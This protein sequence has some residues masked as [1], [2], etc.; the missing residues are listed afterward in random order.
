MKKLI[1]KPFLIIGLFVLFSCGDDFLETL[2]TED[3]SSASITA[4]TGNLLLGINGIHRSLYVR[5]SSQGE[6]GVGGVMITMDVMGEDFVMT[7]AGNGWYN[8]EYQ[9]NTHTNANAARTLYPY[10]IYYRF[11]RNA[12][13][14]INGADDAEGPQTIKNMVKGQALVYRAF[15]HF[16]LVQLY[17]SRYVAGSQNNQPGIPIRLIDDNETLARSSVEEVYAQIHADLDEAIQLLAGYERPNKSHLDQSVAQGIKARVALVQGN[18]QMAIQQAQIARQGYQLMTND[19]YVSGF[20]DYNNREWMWGSH[21]Q[22]DQTL[23]FANFGAYVSRNFNSTNIRT[24]PKAIFSVLYDQLPENDIRR[25][26]WD[27]SGQHGN[28]PAGVTLPSNFVKRP[29][30]SQ[31]FIAAG[32]AD[33]R[34]DVVYMRAAE[35]YLIEAEAKARL[36]DADAARV[37]FELVSPRD[38]EYTM[39]TNTGQA[40]ID[41]ILFY[42]RIEL[43]GEGFRWLD[44][45]RLNQSLDRNG[46]NH[47]ANLINNLFDVPAGDNRWTYQIPQDEI[48]NNPLVEQ[49]PQ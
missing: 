34:M 47:Q 32:T 49:N 30:T 12:N 17:G 41:E 31:K 3:I 42:R 40:L 11:I 15:C 4:T 22:E 24:N 43:W 33:S 37:L 48:N 19:E 2:P 46:G 8:S 38:S 5:Y 39:S 25:S 20:N 36:G 9:W 1:I 10:R 28:L 26:L 23:F 16:Q 44:L 14:L 45:K 35:M 21:M 7:S 13:V 29:Y 18:Y 27:P 6:G